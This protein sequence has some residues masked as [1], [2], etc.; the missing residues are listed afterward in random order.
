MIN[1]KL[2]HTRF[3][4]EFSEQRDYKFVSLILITNLIEYDHKLNLDQALPGQISQLEEG[5]TKQNDI[6]FACV[7]KKGGLKGNLGAL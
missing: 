5:N 1:Y 6:S 3:N 7:R 2:A 4:R